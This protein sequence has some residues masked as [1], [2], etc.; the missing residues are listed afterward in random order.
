M[1]F[2]FIIFAFVRFASH[3]FCWL[4]FLCWTKAN[5]LLTWMSIQLCARAILWTGR[6]PTLPKTSVNCSSLLFS[7][8][9]YQPRHSHSR[10]LH[11]YSSPKLWAN[12]LFPNDLSSFQFHTYLLPHFQNISRCIL[13]HEFCPA[14]HTI[15]EDGLKEEVITSFG[16]MKTSV[17]RVIEAVMQVNL[18]IS[19]PRAQNCGRV[20][21]LTHHALVMQL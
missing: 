3:L 14:L 2:L 20:N 4:S 17:W 9:C 7:P 1:F 5:F 11:C 13:L 18:S 12:S 21:Y 15:L 16:R 19:T 6:T 10:H 8:R